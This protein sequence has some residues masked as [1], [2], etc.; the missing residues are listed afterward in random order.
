MMH[1]SQTNTKDFDELVFNDRNQ[2]YGAY[3][4]RKNYSST[5]LKSLLI[6]VAFTASLLAAPYLSDLFKKEKIV[7]NHKAQDKVTPVLLPDKPEDP[8]PPVDDP[9]PP[10][11]NTSEHLAPVITL[12]DLDEPLTTLEDLA[13]SDPGE[14]THHGD[15][16]EWGI[17]GT[18]VECETVIGGDDDPK[19]TYD[20]VSLQQK[21]E[22]PGGEEAMWRYLGNS[23]I[24]PEHA[25]QIGLEG[26]VH[27]TFVIDEWG[28]VTKVAVPREIGGG[29]D[30]EAARV[31]REMPRWSPGKQGGHAVRVAYHLPIVFRLD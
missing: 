29:L 1:L 18:C 26:T 20:F 12:E 10:V 21:P 2:A 23:L 31:I 25:R 7:K 17:P 15:P 13:I 4:L 19:K 6:G 16:S 24:Y 3:V 8:K 30:E 22:F 9:E 5:M 27:V 28:N 14:V 11:A